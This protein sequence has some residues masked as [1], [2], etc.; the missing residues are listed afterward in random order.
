MVLE[1]QSTPVTTDTTTGT[2]DTV[3]LNPFCAFFLSRKKR[4]CKM[5]VKRGALYCAEHLTAAG[6][7]G[8]DTTAD[9]EGKRISCPLDP[10]HTVYESRLKAHLKKCN[11]SVSEIVPSYFSKDVNIL[12]TEEAQSAP[13]LD[14]PSIAELVGR[15]TAV[16]EVLN[17]DEVIVCERFKREQDSMISETEKHRIQQKALGDLILEMV[18]PGEFEK[19]VVVEFGAGKGGLSSYLWESFLLPAGIASDF[20]LVDRSNFRLKKDAKMRHAGAVVKRLFIDIKDLNVEDLLAGYDRERTY[21]LWVSKHLCGTATCL[22]INSLTKLHGIDRLKGTF[23]VAL[24][25][26]QCC[27]SRTYPNMPFLRDVGLIKSGESVDKVFRM[28]CSITSWAVCGFREAQ[29]SDDDDE[30]NEE[31]DESDSANVKRVKLEDATINDVTVDTVYSMEKKESVGRAMKR[32]FDLGRKLQLNSSFFSR[33]QNKATLKHY[34][35]EEV[36]LE[37]AVL[38]GH[39]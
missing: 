6:G 12:V 30:S 11:A 36:T 3:L 24:C 7:A 9:G 8:D 27:S 23:C 14:K 29:G 35:E 26:H 33:S 1:E 25:C 2:T 20:I 38:I 17:A 34:V 22:T 21:F 19:V 13:E 16:A 10:A 31:G 28:L 32:I 37:N 39:I 5:R 15:I 4:N 18:K